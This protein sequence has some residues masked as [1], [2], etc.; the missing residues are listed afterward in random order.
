MVVLL[1]VVGGA[2]RLQF[3]LREVFMFPLTALWRFMNWYID[4]QASSKGLDLDQ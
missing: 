1:D 3:I 2:V 4:G